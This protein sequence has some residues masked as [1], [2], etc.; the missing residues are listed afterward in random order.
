MNGTISDMPDWEAM[1]MVGG[2]L[3]YFGKKGK[4]P[5]IPTPVYIDQVETLAK[6]S[7]HNL[8][9]HDDAGL[10]FIEGG[11]NFARIMELLQRGFITKNDLDGIDLNGVTC[12]RLMNF[13]RRLSTVKALVINWPTVLMRQGCISQNLKGKPEIMNYHVTTHRYGQPAHDTRSPLDK[14]A[15]GICYRQPPNA[16]T[17]GGGG[18]FKKG[19]WA[20]AIAGQNGTSGVNSM[21]HCSFAAGNFA[22]K[23]VD[24]L[25]AA[26]G[27]DD[28]TDEELA[29]VGAREYCFVPSFGCPFSAVSEPEGRMG[30]ISPRTLVPGCIAEWPTKR[31]RLAYEG[32]RD[33]HSLM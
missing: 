18:G 26:Y 30:Y 14:N 11:A 33:P 1:G 2:N 17:G 22:G 32:D 28:Y 31:C 4:D 10:D 27:W 21:V 15:H 9:L 24:M 29:T 8:I 3:G 20:A 23:S 13:S 19:D 6:T 25:K 16:H 5:S 7:I 12:M